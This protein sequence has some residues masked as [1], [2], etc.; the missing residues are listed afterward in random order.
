MV[1]QNNVVLQANIYVQDQLKLTIN[2]VL[3][4]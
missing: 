3:G 2:V 4:K 1:V